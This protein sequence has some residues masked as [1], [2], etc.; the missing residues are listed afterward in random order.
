MVWNM[1]LEHDIQFTYKVPTFGLTP[2]KADT[3][4][5]IYQKFGIIIYML[6]YIVDIIVASM[7]LHFLNIEETFLHQK[8]L[9]MYIIFLKLKKVHDGLVLP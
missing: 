6:L 4:L 8:I 1:R 3:S 7:F 9:E 2:S 5:F